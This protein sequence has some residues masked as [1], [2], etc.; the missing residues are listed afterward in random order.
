MSFR[1]MSR[2][3]SVTFRPS[4]PLIVDRFQRRGTGLCLIVTPTM[5]ALEPRLIRAVFRRDCRAPRRWDFER[6]AT[7]AERP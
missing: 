2:S 1:D 5:T 3:H 6:A 7:G 4:L